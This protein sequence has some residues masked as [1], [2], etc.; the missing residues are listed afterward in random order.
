MSLAP[1]LVKIGALAVGN[2]FPLALIADTGRMK[3]LDRAFERGSGRV[4]AAGAAGIVTLFKKS[5]DRAF[6][7]SA[8]AS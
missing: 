3:S 6:R 4:E 8:Y 1:H 5:F 7:T 2:D